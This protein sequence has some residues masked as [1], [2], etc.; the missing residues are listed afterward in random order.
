MEYIIVGDTKKFK[1]CLALVC[2]RD[3]RI[4]EEQLEK[5][6]TDPQYIGIAKEYT[7]L[8]VKEV[9]EGECWWNNRLD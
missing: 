2:G 1:N 9:A 4:A 5:C 6:K 7:N 8:R 3:K